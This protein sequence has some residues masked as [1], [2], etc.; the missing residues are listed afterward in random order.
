M[1]IITELRFEL[2]ELTA[3]ERRIIHLMEETDRC[4]YG[5]YK[6][7]SR[8]RCTR[9]ISDYKEVMI[10]KEVIKNIISLLDNN[11]KSVKQ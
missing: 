7:R 6:R 9:L 2:E 10:R 3:D 5:R 11:N 4:N 8:R 1:N